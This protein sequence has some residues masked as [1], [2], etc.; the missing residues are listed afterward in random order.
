MVTDVTEYKQQA[1]QRAVNYV[2]NDMVIGL[3]HGST[4]HFALLEIAK[5]IREG[6]LKNIRVVPCSL[7]VERQAQQRGI[8][9]TTLNEHPS[10]D[11]TIDGADEIDPH[12]NLIKGGGG[13]L[14]REKIVA[15]ASRREIII[16]DVSKLSP[17]LG[18]HRALPVEVIPFGLR[19]EIQFI[20]SLG[21][22][23]TLRKNADGTLFKT[24]QGNYILDCHFGP[25][26]DPATIA[27]LLEKR[28]AVVEHGLFIGI[29]S[30]VIMAGPDGIQNLRRKSASKN[31]PETTDR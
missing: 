25:M 9:L 28:A 16:A 24:D 5:R 27:H 30:D 22:R 17:Q 2:K 6:R 20:E 10:L 18:T 23:V 31:N 19:P 3:G 13:A 26:K 14:L 8:P 1:A 7:E 11:L 21:A 4:A 29:A 12:L 15:Q